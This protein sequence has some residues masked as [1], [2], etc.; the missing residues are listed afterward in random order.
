MQRFVSSTS[1][2]FRFENNSL[3]NPGGAEFFKVYFK[4]C[5]GDGNENNFMCNCGRKLS[6]FG[7]SCEK[8]TFERMVA[9]NE[10]C[11]HFHER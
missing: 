10:R 5:L 11:S 1:N 8:R 2:T 3:D 7:S 6:Q 9:N 4:T